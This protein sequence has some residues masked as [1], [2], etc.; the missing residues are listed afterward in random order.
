[1][2]RVDGN[3]PNVDRSDAQESH[4]L[5]MSKPSF[6]PRLGL[7]VNAALVA[8]AFS[9]LGFVIWQN[10]EKIN[11]V[12]S[13]RLDLRVLVIA[14]AIYMA[15]IVLT[16]VRWFLL[17]RVIEPRFTLSATLL[18]G[19]IGSVFNLV[20]PGAVGGDFIKAAYLVRMHIKKTQAIASM[21]IDR[22]LGLLALFI[23]ASI[24]GGFAWRLA[25]GDVRK[26]IMAAWAAVAMGVL[27][28]IVIFA[29]VS[30]RM[31]P[32]LAHGRSRLGL[33]VTEL[34]EMS[35]TY[36]GRLDLVVGCLVMSVFIHAIYVVA[37]YVVGLMLYSNMTTTLAQH[38]LLAPLTFFTMAVPL[39]FGALGLTEEV[40][41]QLFKL[42]GHPSGFLAM[43]GFRVLMYGGGLIGAC[44]YLAKLKE[45][46]ELTARARQIEEELIDDELDEPDKE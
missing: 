37:F 2:N 23:L 18:L 31:F 17:V 13:R 12:F 15:G 24:A 3:A 22:I 44:V 26:L 38:F 5:V 10:R 25:G 9:L 41:D 42:V 29:Q 43:M 7:L 32:Q 21:V 6:H 46:R 14:F 8:L 11:E 34:R 30:T 40:G 4:R 27:V 36:R 28:L 16:F 1:L 35:T 39:P 45:A 19:F 33:I 20:I